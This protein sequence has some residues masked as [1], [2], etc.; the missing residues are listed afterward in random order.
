MSE[1]PC[2]TFFERNYINPEIRKF[3]DKHLRFNPEKEF[4]CGGCKDYFPYSK[5]TL[6]KYPDGKQILRC[7]KCF[8][9]YK[10]R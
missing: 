5:L 6:I 9:K 3:T 7:V 8:R 4:Q 2:D 10:K 1:N